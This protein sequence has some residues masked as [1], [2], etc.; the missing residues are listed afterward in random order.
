MTKHEA[1][2]RKLTK[3][4]WYCD[5]HGAIVTP[6]GFV[7]KLFLAGS[8]AYWTFNVR[9]EGASYPVKAH[10]LIAFLKFGD[11]AFKLQVRHMNGDSSDNSWNN[12][13]IGTGSQNMMDRAA[14]DRSAHA[15]KASAIG[16]PKLRKLTSDQVL[17]IRASTEQNSVLAKR[18][19]V[20]RTTVSKARRG[21]SYTD[22]MVV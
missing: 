6:T 14:A 13:E 19:G 4:G 20:G 8:P 16:V 9:Y 3:D 15:A 1:V 7:R 5:S 2:I 22:V 17:T 11:A 18:F 21:L 12:L 10:K